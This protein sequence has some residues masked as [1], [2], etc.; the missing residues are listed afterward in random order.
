MRK[1]RKCTDILRLNR[2]I[3]LLQIFKDMYL[4][5]VFPTKKHD[6]MGCH[7]YKTRMVNFTQN[8]ITVHVCFGIIARSAY[9]LVF[10][11]RRNI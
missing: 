11:S 9:R 10:L 3:I 6:P 5:T 1:T 7:D 4:S 8:F 2:D